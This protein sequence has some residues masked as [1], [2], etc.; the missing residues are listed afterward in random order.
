MEPRRRP[1]SDFTVSKPGVPPLVIALIALPALA[2]VVLVGYQLSSGGAQE[3]EVTV[4]DPNREVVA[5]GHDADR[6]V[7]EFK[8]ILQSPADSSSR[9]ERLG[10][11]RDRIYAWQDQFEE[12]TKPFQDSEGYLR[13]EYKGTFGTMRT[14]VNTL[15]NDLLRQLNL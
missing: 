4:T 13:D 11:L 3:K 14:R 15:L 8:K 1:G 7:A 2:I 6:F 10:A 5:L 9:Q 12:L